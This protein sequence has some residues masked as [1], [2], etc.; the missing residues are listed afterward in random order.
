MI[1]LRRIFSRDELLV[2]S[3]PLEVW[4]LLSKLNNLNC[5]ECTEKGRRSHG[6]KR[7]RKAGGE[8]EGYM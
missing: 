5:C 6:K 8:H 4:A 7:E 1:L 2:L 3:S